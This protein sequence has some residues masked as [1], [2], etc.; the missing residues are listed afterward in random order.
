LV[1]LDASV[2]MGGGVLSLD[3]L[4]MIHG[5]RAQS[6]GGVKRNNEGKWRNRGRGRSEEGRSRR[7][8]R[9]ERG[10]LIIEDFVK[11]K[12]FNEGSDIIRTKRLQDGQVIRKSVISWLIS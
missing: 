11:T 4:I 6:R 5:K 12:T 3:S 1:G 7:G 9:W 10:R 2:N 8:R